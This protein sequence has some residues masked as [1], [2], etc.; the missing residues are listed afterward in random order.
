[1]HLPVELWMIIL[2]FL[3]HDE[4]LARQ[5]F[6]KRFVKGTL[7]RSATEEDLVRALPSFERRGAWKATRPYYAID[8]TIRQAAQRVSLS[9]VVL[10]QTCSAPLS[11]VPQKRKKGRK[12]PR[13]LKSKS[14]KSKKPFYAPSKLAK[15]RPRASHDGMLQPTYLALDLFE[16]DRL[17]S[18]VDGVG[19]RDLTIPRREIQSFF[20]SALFLQHRARLTTEGPTTKLDDSMLRTVRTVELLYAAPCENLEVRAEEL[21]DILAQDIESVWKQIGVED[22]VVRVMH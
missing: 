9:A 2:E 11:E 18:R 10:L 21:A 17:E 19:L 8:R 22:G 1:M 5:V 7:E 12:T 13:K 4:Y 15:M 14:S 6:V 20:M 3:R 16:S